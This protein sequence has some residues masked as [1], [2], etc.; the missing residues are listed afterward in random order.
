MRSGTRFLTALAV[1]LVALAA[2][3]CV[4]ATDD[5]SAASY[6]AGLDGSVDQSGF[7]ENSAGTLKVTLYNY[8]TVDETITVSAVDANNTSTVY[9]TVEVVVP[10]GGSAV[11]SL[12]FG[13]GSGTHSIEIICTPSDYFASGYNTLTVQVNVPAS[14]WSNWV[15]YL[16]IVA[17]IIIA[18]LAVY[19]YMRNNVKTKPDTTFTELEAEKR[20]GAAQPEEKKVSTQRRRYGES[21]TKPAAKAEEPK[22]EPK[23]A[24]SFSELHDQQE[25]AKTADQKDGEPKKLKYVSS[26]RK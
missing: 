17:I 14:I 26:R 10:T 22:E 21:D 1:A 11:A 13:L 19:L 12:T 8:D 2:V 6:K 4:F 16:T 18:I 7:A 23:K 20:K 25:A 15:T 3:S 24:A 9:K 5:S